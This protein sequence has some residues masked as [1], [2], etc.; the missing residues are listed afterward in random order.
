MKAEQ[1]KKRGPR[2]EMEEARR[3]KHL[4]IKKTVPAR[5]MRQIPASVKTRATPPAQH[6][7]G[8]VKPCTFPFTLLRHHT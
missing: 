7:H 6:P 1:R 3:G 5:A 8:S 2:L 4:R